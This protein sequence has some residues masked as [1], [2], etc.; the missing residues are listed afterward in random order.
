[1]GRSLRLVQHVEKEAGMRKLVAVLLL[2][3]IT[4]GATGCYTLNYSNSAS[5]KPIS[6]TGEAK[7][8]RTHFSDEKRVWYVLWGLVALSDTE[9]QK[10]MIEPRA[11]G[12]AVQNLQIKSQ[13]SPM[14]VLISFFA[15]ILTF[16][17]QTVTVEGDIVR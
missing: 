12:G 9:I 17:C 11:A 14:D 16:Y 6:F 13:M 7:G 4:L 15:G 8:Q 3:G 2:V 10:T 1:M 5:N